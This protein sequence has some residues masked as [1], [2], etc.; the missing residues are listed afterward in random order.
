MEGRNMLMIDTYFHLDFLLK[1]VT[2]F[3]IISNYGIPDLLYN[4]EF[5]YFASNT[6]TVISSTVNLTVVLR[7]P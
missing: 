7:P 1:F 4:I 5:C 2:S 3:I 6:F